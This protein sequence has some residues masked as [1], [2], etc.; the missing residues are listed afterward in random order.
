MKVLSLDHLISYLAS[1]LFR[2]HVMQMVKN[3]WKY[4]KSMCTPKK[5]VSPNETIKKS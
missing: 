5:H 3:K 2:L 4:T 1:V